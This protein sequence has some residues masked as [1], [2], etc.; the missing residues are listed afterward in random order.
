MDTMYL[1]TNDNCV[2]MFNYFK[3]LIDEGNSLKENDP[4]KSLSLLEKGLKLYR[5]IFERDRI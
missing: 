1:K 4:Q 5:R 2:L 3:E